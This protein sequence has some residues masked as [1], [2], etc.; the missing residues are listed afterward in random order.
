VFED[1]DEAKE[2]LE[3]KRKR[4]EAVYL[5]QERSKIDF[6]MAND[7]KID[8]LKRQHQASLGL[9]S[10]A[11]IDLA[12]R[13]LAAGNCNYRP[14]ATG[15]STG[16][17]DDD[18]MD[19]DENTTGQWNSSLKPLFSTHTSLLPLEVPSQLQS[20]SQSHGSATSHTG[21]IITKSLLLAPVKRTIP[22][23][24]GVPAMAT[25]TIRLLIKTQPS[26]LLRCK[27]RPTHFQLPATVEI[28][29]QW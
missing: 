28:D 27:N 19:E 25:T 8:D 7:Q 9:L 6:A 29:F 4:E 26:Y 14:D 3:R 21:T 12:R 5:E 17:D 18:E 16:D 20:Q 15:I 23:V 11:T 1:E 13:E 2:V 22:N 24:F 10:D